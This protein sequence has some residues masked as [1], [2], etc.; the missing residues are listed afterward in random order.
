[1]RPATPPATP[2]MMAP[3]LGLEPLEEPE[4]LP[5]V[6]DGL[7]EVLTPVTTAPSVPVLV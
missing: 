4:L 2:P 1:M 7:E 5:L 3:R 6:A